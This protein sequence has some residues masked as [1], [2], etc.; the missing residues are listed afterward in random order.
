M[1][2]ELCHALWAR[3]DYVMIL[4]SF[5]LLSEAIYLLKVGIWHI[6]GI[7]GGDILED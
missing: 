5:G 6:A 7:H 1:H 3:A 4:S 2:Q